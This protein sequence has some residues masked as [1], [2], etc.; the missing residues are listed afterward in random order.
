MLG[1]GGWLEKQEGTVRMPLSHPPLEPQ[2]LGMVVP[3][4]LGGG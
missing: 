4:W 2:T 3:G 1:T